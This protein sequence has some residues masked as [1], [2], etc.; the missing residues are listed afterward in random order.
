MPDS[1]EISD[2]VWVNF[3]GITGVIPDQWEKGEIL[4]LF[5]LS[6]MPFEPSVAILIVCS[7]RGH[8]PSKPRKANS[9]DAALCPQLEHKPTLRGHRENVAHGRV[10]M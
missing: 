8:R 1:S 4:G 7:A 6:S 3:G 2:G 5:A 10:G 9:D